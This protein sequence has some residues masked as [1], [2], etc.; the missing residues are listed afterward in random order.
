[1]LKR[2]EIAIISSYLVSLD[3]SDWK[4]LVL[5]RLF[6]SSVLRHKLASNEKIE[7]MNKD[8]DAEELDFHFNLLVRMLF[9]SLIEN[10]VWN[11]RKQNGFQCFV[12]FK[13]VNLILG[14]QPN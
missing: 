8:I 11:K 1:M 9:S 2:Y 6:V 14:P 4:Q 3:D 13:R 5:I 10:F 7:K 12:K